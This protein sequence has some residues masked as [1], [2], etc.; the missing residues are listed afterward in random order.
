MG[1][2]PCVQ[3]DS[4]PLDGLEEGA[5]AAS[6]SSF[7]QVKG[8][9][10][11]NPATAVKAAVATARSVHALPPGASVTPVQ[12]SALVSY[13]IHDLA[14]STKPVPLEKNPT[15][16]NVLHAKST[17]LRYAMLFQVELH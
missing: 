10:L 17:K 3:V 5:I 4:I 8:T 7:N 11:A 1:A 14:T 13:A 12:N 15:P 2:M 6:D 9:A 16:R